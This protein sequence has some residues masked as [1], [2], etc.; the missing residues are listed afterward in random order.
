[1][2]NR[3][4]LYS[5]LIVVLSGC[6]NTRVIQSETSH[7]KATEEFYQS[8][9][10]PSAIDESTLNLFLTKMPK[11]ADIHHHYSGT[12]YAETYLDWVKE[13]GWLINP[14]TSR[15]IT[16]NKKTKIKACDKPAMTVQELLNDNRSFRQLLML[17]SNKDFS[18][19]FH[20]QVPPDSNFFNT[21]GYFG[22]I[23]DDNQAIGLK[24]IKQRAIDEN[25]SYIETMLSRVG[26]KAK[27]FFDNQQSISLIDELR[28]TES[29]KEVDTILKK[30]DDAVLNNSD[31]VSQV[32]SFVDTL[33]QDHQG[34]DQSNFTMRYQSYAV[35]VL[36]PLQVYLDLLAGYQAC[37]TSPLFVGVNI[38]APEN[39]ATA[40]ADYTLHMRMY[41]YLARNYPQVGRAL[42]A[43]ELT[44]GMVRPE[45][46]L[47]HIEEARNI[48]K[49]QRIGHGIDI[50]Y[51]K[52]SINVLKDL[53]ENAV[54]EINL[55][56]NEFI[57]GVKHNAHPYNIYSKY[58]VPMVISTD[59]SGVSRNNLTNEFVLLTTRYRPDYSQIKEYVFNSIKYSFLTEEKQKEIMK[60]LSLRFQVFEKEMSGLWSQIKQAQ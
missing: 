44:L 60:D 20:E 23:S 24:I 7:F 4:T 31:F 38:V 37:E 1:M 51:E 36:N 40:L 33:E 6:A 27:N 25:V 35:R 12:I 9:T 22:P 58:D 59:D 32:K 41:N 50:P 55:T 10:R 28:K 30:I 53:K 15:I 52:N 14:C 5:I 43:G 8:I 47:F 49:A 56:S 11:G 57:L 39:N 18:N 42:H 3:L 54:V 19:H 13:K 17:W 29:Q 34:I 26:V 2:V 21:F 16:S 46:L 48:A 45:D